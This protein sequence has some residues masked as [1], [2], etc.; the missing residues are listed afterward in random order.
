MNAREELRRSE[1]ASAQND[2]TDFRRKTNLRHYVL[3][4]ALALIAFGIRGLLGTIVGDELPFMLFIAAA[5][6][7]AWYGGA[8]AGFVALLLGLVLAE[9]FFQQPKQV[10]GFPSL[11][12]LRFI[13]YVF[14]G[15]LGVVLIGMLHR[16]RDRAKASAERLRIE[17][18]RRKRSEAELQEAK[19]LLSRQNEELERCVDKR[20]AELSA[21]INSLESILYHLAHNLRAPA[22][23]MEGFI[24]LLERDYGQNWDATAHDYASRVSTSAKK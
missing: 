21:S 15:A 1:N 4:V 18:E 17:V 22:R 11:E 20:T 2:I 24:S 12:L 19:N 13:R 9:H 8:L 14:T 10:G 23:A 7:A 6:G 16:D 5:L 3:A